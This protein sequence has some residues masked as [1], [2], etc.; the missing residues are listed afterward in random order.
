[1]GLPTPPS[2]QGLLL[3]AMLRWK[4]HCCSS[5]R[6]KAVNS[7]VRF[8]VIRV[9]CCSLSLMCSHAAGV[10]HAAAVGGGHEAGE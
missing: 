6:N 10:R 9:P 5:V 4:Q 7:H 8:K 2:M 3:K 1:M